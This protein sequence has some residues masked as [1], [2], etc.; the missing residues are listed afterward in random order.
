MVKAGVRRHTVV[1]EYK[2]RQEER[3]VR[4]VSTEFDKK[5]T[6]LE[7][8]MEETNSNSAGLTATLEDV[9]ANN[10]KLVESVLML[11]DTAKIKEASNSTKRK[12]QKL[13][14]KYGKGNRGR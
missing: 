14:E 13:E 3:F 2:K 11:M 10:A 9:I 5:V 7:Q 6:A 8:R 1:E 12:L 4:S